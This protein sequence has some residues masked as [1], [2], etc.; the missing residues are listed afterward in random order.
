[1]KIN[2]LVK[3]ELKKI[4]LK[5]EMCILVIANIVIPL[6][7]L[8]PLMMASGLGDDAYFILDLFIRGTFIIWQSVL[9]SSLIVGEIKTKTMMQLYTYPVKRS[10]LIIAKVGLIFVIILAFSLIT[11]LI[12][13]SLFASLALILPNF[14][15]SLSLSAILRMVVSSISAVMLTMMTLT[16]GVWMKSTIAPV[17]TAFL[18][19][20][21]MGSFNGFSLA[22]N[23]AF[24]VMMGI[25]GTACVIFSINEITKNDLIV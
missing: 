10:A 14:S 13:H 24:M 16:V 6:I 8:A 7:A 1:M 9:I 21:M 4:S 12:Q 25:V 20:S 11:N 3:I 23:L 2:E 17:V 5:K 22:N 15:Y 18:I 19:L